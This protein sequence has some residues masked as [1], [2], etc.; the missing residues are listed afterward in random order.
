MYNPCSAKKDVEF[1]LC[2]DI[3]KVNSWLGGPGER[4][5]VFHN[6]QVQ[7]KANDVT[8]HVGIYVARWLSP[9]Q[10]WTKTEKKKKKMLGSKAK[11]KED[12]SVSL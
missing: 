7:Q 6:E 2:E 8:M 12:L 5:C 9:G 3:A 4:K 11:P 10:D 1:S